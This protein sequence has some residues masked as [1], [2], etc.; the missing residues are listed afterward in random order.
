M[1]IIVEDIVANGHEFRCLEYEGC[2]LI[3]LSQVGFIYVDEM[4]TNM[5]I[6]INEFMESA[7][8]ETAHDILRSLN[9]DVYIHFLEE[10]AGVEYSGLYFHPFLINAF[11]ECCEDSE[12][13]NIY[14]S[15]LVKLNHSNRLETLRL[16]TENNYLK[17]EL[18]E[19]KKKSPLLLRSGREI[20]V[21]GAS[22]K[23]KY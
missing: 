17:K 20:S 1:N 18:K 14:N 5:N 21:D 3:C 7:E 10:D 19:L 23:K 8:Y 11:L 9:Q 12:E 16:S 13:K 15:M 22:K 4:A 6:D 2:F